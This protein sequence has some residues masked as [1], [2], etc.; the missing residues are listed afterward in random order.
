MKLEG[1]T[2]ESGYPSIVSAWA[3]NGTVIDYVRRHSA[4]DLTE[5]VCFVLL[6]VSVP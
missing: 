6:S 4:C 2:M 1:Y 3:E 5:I